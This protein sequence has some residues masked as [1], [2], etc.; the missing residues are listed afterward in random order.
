MAMQTE[1]RTKVMTPAGQ[2]ASQCAECK[3][4]RE[5]TVEIKTDKGVL[6]HKERCPACNGRGYGY[7][8]K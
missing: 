6:V 2:T 3:G 7:A 4:T 8:T 1:Y 5:V